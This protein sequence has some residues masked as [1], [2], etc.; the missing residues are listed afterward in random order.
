[1]ALSVLDGVL[2]ILG[3]CPT[4]VEDGSYLYFIAHKINKR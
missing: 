4:A 3:I 2:L 1:M